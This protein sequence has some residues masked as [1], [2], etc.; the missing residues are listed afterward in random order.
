MPKYDYFVV[1]VVV[2][3]VVLLFVVWTEAHHTY[4]V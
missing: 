3:V 4:L 1:V 2:V